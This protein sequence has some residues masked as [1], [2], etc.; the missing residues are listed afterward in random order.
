MENSGKVRAWGTL[1]SFQHFGGVEGVLELRD[2]IRKSDKQ[3]TH[4]H[5]PAKN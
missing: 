1:P 3:F 4:L 2:G 5:E